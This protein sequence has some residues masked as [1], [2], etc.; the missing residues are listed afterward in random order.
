MDLHIINW[1]G[2]IPS[3]QGKPAR[4]ANSQNGNGLEEVHPLDCKPLGFGMNE[5]VV[6][7]WLGYVK[8]VCK[9]A[10][11]KEGTTHQSQQE[12]RGSGR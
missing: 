9:L 11:S 1:Q 3:I 6:N 12:Y 2:S 5:V 8:C 4:L 7:S 10:P